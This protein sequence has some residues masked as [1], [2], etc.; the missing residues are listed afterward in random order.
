MKFCLF[1]VFSFFRKGNT[2]SVSPERR[3]WNRASYIGRE[4]EELLR[5]VCPTLHIGDEMPAML[6]FFFG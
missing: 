3:K 1:L 5:D 4:E 2:N 6:G